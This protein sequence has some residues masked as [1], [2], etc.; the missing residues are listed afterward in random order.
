[1]WKNKLYDHKQELQSVGISLCW[2]F[3]SILWKFWIL[4]HSL[5]S[6][7]SWERGKSANPPN[8]QS[9]IRGLLFVL[10]DS[11]EVH[12]HTKLN[13]SA[14]LED[15]SLVRRNF[16]RAEYIG[17]VSLKKTC[18]TDASQGQLVSS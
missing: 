18:G 15:L 3:I 8:P 9:K 6:L 12:M 11:T 16:A 2:Y 7:I 17:I 4:E 13:L 5:K 1:M 10:S 14:S